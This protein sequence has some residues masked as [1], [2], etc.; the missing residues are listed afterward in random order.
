[1]TV[2]TALYVSGITSYHCSKKRKQESTAFNAKNCCAICK[3]T[4]THVTDHSILSSCEALASTQVSW[5]NC[6]TPLQDSGSLTFSYW[7][8]TQPT[9]QRQ[10]AA[11][12]LLQD[13]QHLAV[14]VRFLQVP[15][16]TDIPCLLEITSAAFAKTQQEP[17]SM[18][19]SL[20][21]LLCISIRLQLNPNNTSE[22]HQLLAK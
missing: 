8:P 21:S 15:R 1:M 13:M 18:R 9:T 16:G 4:M 11:I 20:W 17:L 12:L 22:D 14:S 3:Q 2:H 6:E 5:H 10:A 7:N 19:G